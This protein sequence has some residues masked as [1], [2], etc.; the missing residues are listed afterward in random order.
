MTAADVLKTLDNTM[1]MKSGDWLEEKLKI[2]EKPIL[3]DLRGKN[4]WEKGHI[5]GS[6]Q[7]NINN[8]PAKTSELIPS[9]DSVIIC[10]CNG[11]VQSAMAA[12]YLRTEDYKN[13]YNLSGG[14]SAWVR[15]E[16]AVEIG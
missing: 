15:N 5:T 12:M 10:I 2:G 9:M 4:A 3:I 8:L 6:I 16:R 11:S 7:V 13:T 14:Y 1:A